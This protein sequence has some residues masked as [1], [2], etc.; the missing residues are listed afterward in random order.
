MKVIQ[1]QAVFVSKLLGEQKINTA[2]KYRFLGFCHFK[3]IDDGYLLF[4]NLTKELLY[5]TV[6]EDALLKNKTYDYSDPFIAQLIKKWFLVPENCDD[7]KLST[8]ITSLVKQLANSNN[9][10]L[11]NIVTTTACNA[12][13]FYCFE[14]GVLPKFMNEET[15]KDVCKYIIE[16]YGGK[17]VKINWFGGEPLCNYKAID[18]ISEY[19]SQRS[20]SFISAMTTNGYLFDD[21]IILKAEKLWNL[22]KV[23]ITLDGME[24][25]YNR[26]KNYKNTDK[27]P[28]YRVIDNINKLLHCGISVN[29]RL[30]VDKYNIS[31]MYSLVDYLYSKFSNI[32][33]FTVYAHLLFEDTGFVK[34]SR[35]E[36][37][38]NS[39]AEEFIAFRRYIE[40]LGIWERGKLEKN[41][42][43][44]FCMADSVNAVLV[45]PEGRLG[46]CEHYV[47][48]KF[49]GD[50]Y[51]D[52]VVPPDKD[53]R[54]PI[55]RC[56][57]C[58]YFPSCMRLADCPH[59]QNECYE[60]EQALRLMDLERQMLD[61]Y[62]N[63]LS[64]NGR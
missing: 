55:E 1:R 42:K 38:R 54:K 59:C 22:K 62:K 49:S 47:D 48:S 2:L 29:I 5:I 7:I 43:T 16:N 12:R 41:I 27:N 9:I 44:S 52:N 57:S 6:R 45:S 39:I 30:N 18:I 32:K 53:Y 34:I 11:Y 33:G 35:S 36:S 28:F 50:I 8:Q 61:A 13:C 64:D 14:A 10:T 37:E 63:Y 51:S 24:E 3:K 4:N 25:T 19:L 17:Q 26:V 20:V 15:C 56:R 60:Y 31:E 46:K 58:A 40:E 21:N 23:Q